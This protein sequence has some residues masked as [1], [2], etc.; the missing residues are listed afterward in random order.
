MKKIFLILSISIIMFSCSSLQKND[1]IYDNIIISN[2][3]NSDTI[4]IKST[5]N[6]IK[7]VLLILDT[8]QLGFRNPDSVKYYFGKPN[9]VKIDTS[10]YGEIIHD[11]GSTFYM[12][13]HDYT[14]YEY[15]KNGLIKEYRFDAGVVA[16][17]YFKTQ[18]YYSNNRIDSI[19][20][21]NQG[22]HSLVSKKGEPEKWEHDKIFKFIIKYKK[23]NKISTIEASDLRNEKVAV[24][25]IA[26]SE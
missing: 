10:E 8:L 16:D 21:I 15:D 25:N 5:N 17:R 3:I 24:Y 6:I 22:V 11:S 2:N 12:D 19:T 1:D 13:T 18:Y 20:T 9:Q 23:E 26:Y 7:D 4:L 14:I